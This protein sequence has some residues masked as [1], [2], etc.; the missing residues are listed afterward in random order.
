M[1]EGL[2]SIVTPVY[3]AERFINETIDSVIAQTYDNWELILVDDC[4][5]D[6]SAAIIDEYVK[7]DSRVKYIKNKENSGAAVSRNAGIEMAKGQYVAFVDSDDVWKP[8]KLEKQLA[9]MKK[10]NYAF[11]FTAYRY[12]LEDGTVTDKIANTV[13]KINYDGLLK[14]TVIGCSTVVI[15]RNIVGD[16]R[17]PLLRRGQDTATWLQILKK[18]DYAYGL[19]EQLVEYRKVSNSISSNKFKALKRTWNIYRNVEHLG[20][21]KS[22]YVFCCYAFN[23]LMRRM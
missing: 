2:V 12:V 3:N 20:L 9:F 16:F 5:S 4:S 11:T 1:Q 22:C 15:D 13:E 21:F 6:N 23:A 7:K 10:N 14:N 17:M 8:E 18:I 19:N